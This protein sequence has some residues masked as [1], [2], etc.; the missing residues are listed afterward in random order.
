MVKMTRRLARWL[1]M[2]WRVSWLPL[3]PAGSGRKTMRVLDVT[4][5]SGEQC[6]VSH[7]TKAGT[8]CLVIKQGPCHCQSTHGWQRI[9]SESLEI[10]TWNQIHISSWVIQQYLSSQRD[11]FGG[12]A[13]LRNRMTDTQEHKQTFNESLF[14]INF[15]WWSCRDKGSK[16]SKCILEKAETQAR[17][18]SLRLLKNCNW[19]KNTLGLQSIRLGKPRLR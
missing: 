15:F 16:Q 10:T 18:E 17:D 3:T 5:W 7:G 9:L 2:T 14:F 4:R 12:D 13:F 8:Q 6:P 19:T 1:E 11:L